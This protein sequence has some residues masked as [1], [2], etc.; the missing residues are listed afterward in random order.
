MKDQG[1]N[2]DIEGMALSTDAVANLISNLQKTGYLPQHR[3]QGNHPGREIKDMQ[4]FQFTLTCEKGKVVKA[5]P[6][7]NFGEMSGVK[8]WAGGAGRRSADRQRL[9]F[10]VFKT[11]RDAECGG[12]ACAGNQAAG[13]RRTGS[14]T[15]RSWRRSSG[16]WPA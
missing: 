13:E 12:A 5:E 3:N 11:Q 1:A 14:R 9:Y 4:A 6:M 7:A 2:V 10:T 15:G 16:S 8:Q